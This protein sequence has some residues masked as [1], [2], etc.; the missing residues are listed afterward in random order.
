[1]THPYYYGIAIDKQNRVW[2]GGW[3][4]GGT[5][6]RIDG[7]PPYTPLDAHR[8]LRRHRGD[9]APRRHASGA[10]YGTATPGRRVKITLD[11][12]GQRRPT[13]AELRR[14]Q[15]LR[16]PR[17]RRRPDG[18]LWSSQRFGGT[19][20]RWDPDTGAQRATTFAVD[21]GHELYTYSDYH[22][23]PAP[24]HHDPRGALVP[25]LRLRLP[26]DRPG[27]TPSGPPSSPPAPASRCR[28]ARPT[29][30]PTSPP[31]LA[32]AWCGP[33]PASPGRLRARRAP[34]STATASSRWT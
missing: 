18:K 25:G 7:D 19:V 28:C 6:H 4:G 11:A 34:S 15:R 12:T 16:E 3:S 33:F 17:R 31:A 32:T 9:R 22:R 8:R 20:N 14:S 13:V 21:A 26:H 10:R 27:I 23:H 1:M 29:T 24:D 2:F 5:M 30:R